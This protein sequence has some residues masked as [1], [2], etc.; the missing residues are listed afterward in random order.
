MFILNDGSYFFYTLVIVQ[1]IKPSG[2]GTYKDRKNFNKG[3]F[4]LLIPYKVLNGNYPKLNSIIHLEY[5][6]MYQ[7]RIV[8][9]YKGSSDDYD[10]MYHEVTGYL[11]ETGFEY[12]YRSTK[13]I[14]DVDKLI[15]RSN[16]FHQIKKTI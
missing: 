1:A 2:L 16:Y 12:F 9:V 14:E 7:F 11:R 5:D 3:D 6:D 4:Q 10:K 8:G 15:E 13:L